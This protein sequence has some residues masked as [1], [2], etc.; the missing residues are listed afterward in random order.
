MAWGIEGDEAI[1]WAKLEE[2]PQERDRPTLAATVI[3]QGPLRVFNEV[4]MRLDTPAEWR[5]YLHGGIFPSVMAT[6]LSET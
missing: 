6:L 1:E 4:T 3:D 5:L 2:S